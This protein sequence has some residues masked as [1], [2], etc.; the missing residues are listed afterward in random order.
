MPGPIPKPM[1][2]RE[3]RNKV[4]TR[5]SLAPESEPRKRAP[6]LPKREG[7]WHPMTRAWWRD[8]WHSPM[9]AEYIRADEHGLFRLAVLVDQF[10]AHPTSQLAAEIRL[11]QQAFGLTPIDRRRLEWSIEQAESATTKRQQRKVRQ[12]HAGE[13]DPRE[14]LK[15]SGE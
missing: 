2:L 5:A 1:A 4:A 6:R 14:A 13:I 3:R 12:A 9:A 7:D 15:V 11:Q 10:W 8:V